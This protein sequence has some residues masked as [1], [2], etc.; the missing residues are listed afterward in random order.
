MKGR[1]MNLFTAKKTGVLLTGLCLCA[2]M[3]LGILV[4]FGRA[5]AQTEDLTAQEALDALGES[6]ALSDK[7]FSFTIPA[8]YQPDTDWLIQVS[9]RYKGENGMSMSLHLVDSDG[10]SD[11]HLLPGEGRLYL[12]ELLRELERRGYRGRATIEL[13]TAYIAEP[14]LAARRA[15]ERVRAMLP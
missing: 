4:T 14:T 8:G 11:T 3:L 2:A 12:P 9:G 5:Q 1:I 6:V 15:V 10:T 7:E 13:V